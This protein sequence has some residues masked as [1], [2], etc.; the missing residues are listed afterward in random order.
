MKRRLFQY[1][2]S[3]YSSKRQEFELIYMNFYTASD[4]NHWWIDK[5]GKKE[6]T[7]MGLPST[8]ENVKYDLVFKG[9][10][11]MTSAHICVSTRED[12]GKQLAKQTIDINIELVPSG[13]GK[14]DVSGLNNATK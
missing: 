13:N 4:G 14:T 8:T 9:D 11:L 7:E 12:K 1:N 6:E 5:D 2:V 3:G 10:Q